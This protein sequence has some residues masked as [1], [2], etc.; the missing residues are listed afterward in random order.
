MARRDDSPKLWKEELKRAWRELRGAQLSPARAAAAVALGLF[1][2]SIPAYGIHTPVVLAI[3]LLFQLDFLL[4]WVASNISNPFFSPFL[5]SGEAQVG[6]YV[7]TGAWLDLSYGAVRDL[8]REQGFGSFLWA[9]LEHIAVGAPFVATGLAVVGAVVAYGTVYA[10]RRMGA[11]GVRTPYVLPDDAPPWWRATER[12]AQRYAPVGEISTPAERTRFHYVRI[13]LLTDPVTKMIADLFD[14][15]GLGELCDIGTGR[16]QLPLVMLELGRAR[17]AWG[18]DWDEEKIAGAQAAAALAPSLEA[19]FEVGDAKSVELPTSDTVLL[20]DVIHY[21]TLA[22]QDAL[23]AR[24]ARAV[25]PGGRLVV[26]EADT[27]RGWR[28]FMTLAEELFFT[29][30]RFNR[31]ARVKFRPARDIAAVL[32]AEGLRADVCPA[33]GGT[34]FSNVLVIGKRPRRDERSVELPENASLATS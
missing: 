31:G 10:R 16:G 21:L 12:V 13:K 33:W 30:V 17:R 11:S 25:R 4:A 34:P 27:E 28:S 14:E 32:E 9:N 29:L 26:R 7:R 22:E 24:A 15:G 23:L 1:V 6:A 19:R 3:C 20:I 5:L 18:V 8:V 2:G